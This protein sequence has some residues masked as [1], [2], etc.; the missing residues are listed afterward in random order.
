[1]HSD[2]FI[3]ID[4]D[5]IKIDI[6]DISG[7]RIWSYTRNSTGTKLNV[8]PQLRT[9]GVYLVNAIYKNDR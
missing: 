3:Q 5:V 8:R 1:M 9:D 4:E 2:A 6:C 7:R